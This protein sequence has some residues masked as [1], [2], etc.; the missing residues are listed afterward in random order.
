M[1]T[2]TSNVALL[3]FGA[4][5]AAFAAL[6]APR[7]CALRAWD[8]RLCTGEAAALRARIEAA[9]VDAVPDLATALRG[10]RLVVLDTMAAEALPQAAQ[11]GQRLLDL[12]HAPAADVDAVLLALGLPPQAADWAAACAANMANCD[13][14]GPDIPVVRR[15]ELP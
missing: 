13:A 10:A 15:G 1:L 9:G 11:A 14:A 6:L 12:A 3:G 5:A 4:R 2:P 8:P 7:G